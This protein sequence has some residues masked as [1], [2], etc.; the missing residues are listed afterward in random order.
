M[1]VHPLN[2]KEISND[3]SGFFWEELILSEL[4]QI[5]MSHSAM[6]LNCFDKHLSVAGMWELCSNGRRMLCGRESTKEGAKRPSCCFNPSTIS[7]MRLLSK[8]YG[9]SLFTCIC[10][11]F[12]PSNSRRLLNCFDSLFIED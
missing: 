10:S 5:M 11:L 8:F 1:H 6:L 12:F 4:L 3:I 7:C 9:P 2:C